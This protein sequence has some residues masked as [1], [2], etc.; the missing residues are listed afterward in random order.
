MRA[1]VV[2]ML[3][4]LCGLILM[5]VGSAHGPGSTVVSTNGSVLLGPRTANNSTFHGYLA[6][7]G[8]PIGPGD[9]LKFAWSVDGGAGPAVY[10]EIHA[11]P[12]NSGYVRY[13]SGLNVTEAGSWS[14]PGSD[15]YMVLWQNPNDV[16]VNVTYGFQLYPPPP[17]LTVLYVFPAAL[18]A[19]AVIVFFAYRRGRQ[20]S[21]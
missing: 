18:G 7:L 10:F 16:E 21:E 17:D 11:H 4:L 5:P 3:L 2:G 20:K 1:L 14:V 9:T 13:V 19:F 15:S 8:L 12:G 6:N